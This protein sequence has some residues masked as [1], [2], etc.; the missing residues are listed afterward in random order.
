MD[1]QTVYTDPRVTGAP[2]VGDLVVIV[3]DGAPGCQFESIQVDRGKIDIL[4]HI[5]PFQDDDM[6]PWSTRGSEAYVHAVRRPT[7]AELATYYLS[8]PSTP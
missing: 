2:Q 3:W 5:A 1:D 6:H 7:E 8:N 4:D